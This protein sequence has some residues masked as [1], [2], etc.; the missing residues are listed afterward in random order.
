MKLVFTKNTMRKSFLMATLASCILIL[1]VA[2]FIVISAMKEQV[3]L[4]WGQMGIFLLSLLSGLS[5]MAYMKKEQ[6]K[7]EAKIQTEKENIGRL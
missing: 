1:S 2:A 4:P 6:K 7:T 3:N 5:G